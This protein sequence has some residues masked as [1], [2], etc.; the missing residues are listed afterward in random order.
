MDIKERG[1]ECVQGAQLEAEVQFVW[2]PASVKLEKA[3]VHMHPLHPSILFEAPHTLT[4][5][6]TLL[7]QPPKP[8]MI[9]PQ[10]LL[11][12]ATIPAAFNAVAQS[13]AL[14]HMQFHL[15]KHHQQHRQGQTR[16]RWFLYDM[17]NHGLGLSCDAEGPSWQGFEFA[18]FPADSEKCNLY[19]MDQKWR[20]NAAISAATKLKQAQR[21]TLVLDLDQTVLHA[22]RVTVESQSQVST[23]MKVGDAF[24]KVDIRAGLL[25]LV[26]LAYGLDSAAATPRFD[27]VYCTH[28]ERL[29]GEKCLMALNLVLKRQVTDRGIIDAIDD[30][31]RRERLVAVDYT[32][33]PNRS[34]PKPKALSDILEV[35]L[36]ADLSK[37]LVLVVDNKKR[38][39]VEAD[40]ENVVK[41]DDQQGGA[42]YSN[43]LSDPT[44][45]S[46]L[47]S[48][49]RAVYER[50]VNS[51][52]AISVHKAIQAEMTRREYCRLTMVPEPPHLPPCEVPKQVQSHKRPRV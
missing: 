37:K 3:P 21:L 29:Y 23:T 19:I 26:R 41:I 25:D 46:E 35:S 28:G 48:L 42:S 5:M 47:V 44:A 27:V 33:M 22:Y 39:W 7:S 8:G 14:A 2:K 15:P 6:L 45:M 9:M 38:A 34:N 30:V 50:V 18:I 32:L 13:S 51:G 4:G 1:P 40:W 49:L 43:G 24:Y 52:Y 17:A 31:T 12:R 36:L 11:T 16:G 10:R 20:L